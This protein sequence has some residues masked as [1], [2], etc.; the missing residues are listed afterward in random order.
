VLYGS[1]TPRK[2]IELLTSAL[3]LEPTPMRLVLAGRP[4][5]AYVTQLERQVAELEAS[6]VE[7]E[8]RAHR[9]SEVEGLRELAGASCALLPY[10]RHSGMSRVLVEAASVGTPVVAHHFGLLGYLVRA[11]RLGLSVDCA[12]PRALRTAV[13]TMADPERRASYAKPLAAFSARFA[14]NRFRATLLSG[15]GLPNVGPAA[16]ESGSSSELLVDHPAR[17]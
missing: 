11:S 2:G 14:P 7:V 10:P 6:G 4:D 5:P 13:L 17:S 16:L 15:L 8:L 12:D 3:T 1:L 9:H